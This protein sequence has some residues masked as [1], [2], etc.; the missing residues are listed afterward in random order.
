[1]VK[2][3]QGQFP[4]NPQGSKVQ[5]IRSESCSCCCPRSLAFPSSERLVE[6][7]VCSYFIH[8]GL[9]ELLQNFVHE[10]RLLQRSRNREDQH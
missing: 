6:W 2:E 7:H 1:M 10:A 5:V 8:F 4:T 3:Q 9:A